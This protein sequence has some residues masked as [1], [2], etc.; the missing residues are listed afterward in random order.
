MVKTVFFLTIHLILIEISYLISPRPVN[1]EIDW[2][3]NH[4]LENIFSCQ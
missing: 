3:N 2:Q 1:T 4:L